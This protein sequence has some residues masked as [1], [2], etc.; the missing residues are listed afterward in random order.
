MRRESVRGTCCAA[1]EPGIARS[2]IA[3]TPAVETTALATPF[4]KSRRSIR[5]LGWRRNSQL[6]PGDAR[7][8]D[9]IDLISRQRR[10]GLLV[11][12][13][14]GVRLLQENLVFDRVGDVHP[15]SA[16]PGPSL[17]DLLRGGARHVGV[18]LDA[19]RIEGEV[20]R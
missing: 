14:E 20:G 13:D 8:A 6:V 19:V 2:T 3:E 12:P 10:V 5:V 17:G 1:A 16:Q 11:V 4:R 18:I 7:V 15:R 9:E